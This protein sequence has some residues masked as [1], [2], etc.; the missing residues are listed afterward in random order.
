MM[1]DDLGLEKAI[2]LLRPHNPRWIDLGQRECEAVRRLL[3]GLVRDV[4]HI[5]STA[6]PELDAKPILDIAVAVSDDA[7]IDD[8][9]ECM[10][11]NGE[12]AYEGDKRDDGGILFVRGQGTFRTVHVHVVGASSRAWTQYLRFQELLMADP[13]AR[14]SYQAEKRKLAHQFPDDRLSY[15]NAKSPIIQE[16]LEKAPTA[17]TP[18]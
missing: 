7:Q 2:V 12:Y 13:E 6:V 4:V 3:N 9:I 18:R 5:G 10:A 15:T 14:G 8:V 16:L 17:P 11:E 1:G